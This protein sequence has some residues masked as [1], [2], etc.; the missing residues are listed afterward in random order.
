MK[1]GSERPVDST[2]GAL[3]GVDNLEEITDSPVFRFFSVH[4]N[5]RMFATRAYTFTRHRFL[6]SIISIH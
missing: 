1:R 6:L 5:H 2:A 3:A 4:F